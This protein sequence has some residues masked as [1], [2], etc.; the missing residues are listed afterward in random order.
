LILKN[1]GLA[2]SFSFFAFISPVLLGKTLQDNLIKFSPIIR[3]DGTKSTSKVFIGANRDNAT[4]PS[5]S[6]FDNEKVSINGIIEPESD[7]LGKD[8]SLFAVMRKQ[9]GSSKIFY[10]LNQD[11][12]WEKWNGSLKNLPIYKEIIGLSAKIEVPI[13]SGIINA[14]EVNIYL[15]YSTV[16][17]GS[18]PIIH[19]NSSPMKIKIDPMSERKYEIQIANYTEYDTELLFAAT[20]SVYDSAY[21]VAKRNV[22]TFVWPIGDYIADASEKARSYGLPFSSNSVVMSDIKREEIIN[23]INEW[24]EKRCSLT[25]LKKQEKD[26]DYLKEA[27]SYMIEN[28]LDASTAPIPCYNVGMGFIAANPE[29]DFDGVIYV[30][31]H[32]TYHNVQMDLEL[33]SCRDRREAPGASPHRWLSEG[34]AHYAARMAMANTTSEK[35]GLQMILEDAYLAYQGGET[36]L[37][38]FQGGAALA[39]M[40]LR[41]DILESEILT[42]SMWTACQS[43][44]IYNENNPVIRYATD[45]WFQI[46]LDTSN[47]VYSFKPSVL[48]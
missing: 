32:E 45:N 20:K 26:L 17:E 12:V 33:F 25:E 6:F 34:A 30:A 46:D 28:G 13:Y 24:V 31:A 43:Q 15:G 4:T 3:T 9:E 10:A 21:D 11:G 14:K 7:D 18:K 23:D 1:I 5:Q 37:S 47:G 35:S 41:G 40:V 39:L 44:D 36:E 2:F 42:A 48:P 38:T 8:G 27:H 16:S 22:R 29:K 19:V